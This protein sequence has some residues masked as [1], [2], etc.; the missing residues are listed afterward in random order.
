[1]RVE[2]TAASRRVS[3]GQTPDAAPLVADAARYPGPW[4]DRRR[5]PRRPPQP[6]SRLRVGERPGPRPWP[7]TAARVEQRRRC[8]P[9][10]GVLPV[11][12]RRHHQGQLRPLS[13]CLT[14]RRLEIPTHVDQPSAALRTWC[15]RPAGALQ[16]ATAGKARPVGLDRVGQVATHHLRLRRGGAWPRRT[17]ERPVIVPDNPTA[18]E[19]GRT[20]RV[21]P[22]PGA[23]HLALVRAGP[24]TAGSWPG[25]RSRVLP[26]SPA[27][28]TLI[29]RPARRPNH[30]VAPSEGRRTLN[31]VGAPRSPDST[32]ESVGVGTTKPVWRKG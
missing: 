22:C 1:M 2:S 18:P 14:T 7:G 28:S 4:L 31:H 27:P 3:A 25:V 10:E 24:T 5:P 30:Y 6:R 9:A 32:R 23:R 11:G 21:P 20:R 12:C 16:A 26:G 29:L 15:R 17:K 8:Q 13:A 19:A